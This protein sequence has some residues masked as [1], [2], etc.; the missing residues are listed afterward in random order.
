MLS[1]GYRGWPQ[2]GSPVCKLRLW[3]LGCLQLSK[4]NENRHPPAACSEAPSSLL[5]GGGAGAGCQG[6]GIPGKRSTLSYV[7][8]PQR[9][10]SGYVVNVGPFYDTKSQGG[11]DLR[12]PHESQPRGLSHSNGGTRSPLDHVL[13]GQRQEPKAIPGSSISWNR[14]TWKP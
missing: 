2:P 4:D 6:L 13:L 8:G 14:V 7:L 12:C 9:A 11:N 5:V 3:R 10:L 1:D